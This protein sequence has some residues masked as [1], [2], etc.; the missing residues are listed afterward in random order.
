M[1]SPLSR[2]RLTDDR[3]KE[4]NMAYTVDFGFRSMTVSR[5]E[6]TSPYAPSPALESGGGSS[7]C[8]T[9]HSHRAAAQRFHSGM[10]PSS[11]T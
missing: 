1:I 3:K 11:L 9:T 5:F 8:A 7:K 4:V 6:V 2:P 10:N